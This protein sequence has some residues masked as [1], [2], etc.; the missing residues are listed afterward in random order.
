M[1]ID[2]N[3]KI[4]TVFGTAI[5]GFLGVDQDTNSTN[6]YNVSTLIDIFKKSTPRCKGSIHYWSQMSN[7][8]ILNSKYLSK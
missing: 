6:T 2:P 7:F 4:S 1:E 8:N 3:D 5:A